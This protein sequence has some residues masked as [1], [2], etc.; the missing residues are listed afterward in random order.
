M[1][2]QIMLHGRDYMITCDAAHYLGIPERTIA[3]WARAGAVKSSIQ[4]G[5]RYICISSALSHLRTK[6]TPLIRRLAQWLV[7]SPHRKVLSVDQMVTQAIKDGIPA[8]E[9][10]VRHALR[11]LRIKRRMH[12]KQRIIEQWLTTHPAI[13]GLTCRE[14]RRHLESDGIHASKNTIG[15]SRK[16]VQL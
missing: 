10:S 8:T 9:P 13:A 16:Q 3:R 15:R 11:L 1:E 12:T 7:A 14:I 6:P 5:R 4:K 2:R